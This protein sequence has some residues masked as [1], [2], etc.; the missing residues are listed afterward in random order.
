MKNLIITDNQAFSCLIIKL[1]DNQTMTLPWLSQISD[2]SE[3]HPKRFDSDNQINLSTLV[4][5]FGVNKRKKNLS[6]YLLGD[7]SND[8]HGDDRVEQLISG[9][10]KRIWQ[11]KGKENVIFSFPLHPSFWPTKSFDVP[12]VNGLGEGSRSLFTRSLTG[13]LKFGNRKKPKDLSVCEECGRE[14]GGGVYDVVIR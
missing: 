5:Y 14:V 8:R 6:E 9:T 13:L 7:T 11:R 12:V 10:N 2:T 1:F 4:S 3:N